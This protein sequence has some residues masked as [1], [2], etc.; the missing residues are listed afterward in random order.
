MSSRLRC[1]NGPL[2]AI[3][4]PPPTPV[5]TATWPSSLSSLFIAS[6]LLIYRHAHIA[7]KWGIVAETGEINNLQIQHKGF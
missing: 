5:T 2:R 1:K 7:Q 3:A 4:A 6:S